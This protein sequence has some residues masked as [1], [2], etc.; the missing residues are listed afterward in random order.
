MKARSGQSKDVL[1][2]IKHVIAETKIP[3]KVRYMLHN[4]G[5]KH[6]GRN[7]NEDRLRDTE[8]PPSKSR[9]LQRRREQR[10][11]GGGRT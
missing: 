4:Q 7:T 3:L 8:G 5:Q 10:K 6:K 11:W 1:L 9:I 2:N